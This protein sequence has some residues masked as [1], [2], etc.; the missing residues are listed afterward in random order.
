MKMGEAI[1]EEFCIEV[2]FSP[3]ISVA[4]AYLSMATQLKYSDREELKCRLEVIYFTPLMERMVQAGYCCT[5]VQKNAESNTCTA[6]FEKRTDKN[7]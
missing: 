7:I 6:W 4:P 3:S 1:C 5:Q 2:A